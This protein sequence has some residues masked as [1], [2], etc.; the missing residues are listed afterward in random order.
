MTGKEAWQRELVRLRHVARVTN[1]PCQHVPS[2]ASE[3]GSRTRA[4]CYMH[5]SCFTGDASRQMIRTAPHSAQRSCHCQPTAAT[6][7]A[8]IPATTRNSLLSPYSR[9]SRYSHPTR[10]W[11]TPAPPWHG[12]A[13][14]GMLQQREG[15]ADARPTCP[16]ASVLPFQPCR[17]NRKRNSPSRPQGAL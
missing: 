10:W 4:S 15:K 2:F 1:L 7:A 17:R 12:M 14:H 5:D 16:P 3:G 13:W 11:C 9:Y 8:A 6:A